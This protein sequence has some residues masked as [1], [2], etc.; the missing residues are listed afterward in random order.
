MMNL[1]SNLFGDKPWTQSLT[2]WGLVIYVAGEA[3]VGEIC[4]G[5]LISAEVCSLLE[6]W[7]A[8]V[9]VVLTALGIRRA[10]N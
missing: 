7:A 10:A 3:A 5:E 4:G 2:A 9:G 1:F 6:N 8:T